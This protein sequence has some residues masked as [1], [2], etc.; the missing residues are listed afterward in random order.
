MSRFDRKHM[1]P[2]FPRLSGSMNQT[3]LFDPYCRE[4]VVGNM[5]WGILSV[6]CVC[7]GVPAS[8]WLLWVLIR[9]QRSGSSNDIYMLNLTI[10]D[11]MFVATILPYNLNV[12][13]W[14]H[15]EFMKLLAFLYT[16]NG[17]GR[18]LL[19][20]CICSDCYIAVRY[21]VLYMR[22][23]HSR[24]RLGVCAAAWALTISF[25]I[26]LTLYS[27][28]I[29]LAVPYIFTLPVIVGCDIAIVCAL[30]RPD[31]S[32]KTEVHPQKKRALQAITHS[33]VLTVLS[34][35]PPLTVPV[36]G[37]LIALSRQE[38]YCSV[39][40]PSL[41]AP[42]LASV[43]LP[44]LHLRSLGSFRGLRRGGCGCRCGWW[45]SPEQ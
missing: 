24:Y 8:V 33:L 42:A 21:P 23:K 18:P 14:K 11:V 28:S 15:D 38:M 43:V 20:A 31:P 19:M 44:L 45:W 5:I 41:T 12:F 39:T 34:F 25:G 27:S 9:R 30:R 6:P 16:F 7:V 2:T 17:S 3:D 36:L 29:L 35:L 37:P 40:M 4:F 1:E 32:G 26:M 22:M 10:M 13:L